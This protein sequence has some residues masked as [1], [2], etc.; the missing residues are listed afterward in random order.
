MNKKVLVGIVAGLCL[1]AAILVLIF[2]SL[3][4]PKVVGEGAKKWLA[5]Y[6]IYVDGKQYKA[7]NVSF[8]Q[9]SLYKQLGFVSNKIDL[10][11]NVTEAKEAN[12]SLNASDAYGEYKPEL[13]RAIE[14]VVKQPRVEEIRLV[15]SLPKENFVNVFGEPVPNK[16]YS[17]AALMFNIKVVNV[18]NV[19]EEVFVRWDVKKGDKS[20]KDQLGFWREVID[21]DES[22]NLLRTKIYGNATSIPVDFGRI[23]IYFDEDYIYGKL[24][25]EIGKV[26]QWN[27]DEGKA[28]SFN[29]THI[30]LDDNNEAAGKDVVVSIKILG[31]EEGKIGGS[32]SKNANVDFDVFIMSYC[33]Y[34]LQFVKGLL[35]VWEEFDDKANIN[36][37]FVSYTM[38]GQ[39]EADENARMVC[40]R[41]E[42]CEKYRDYLKCFVESGNAQACIEKV[43]IDKEKLSDCVANR[44]KRYLEE[45]AKLN[46]QYGVRGSPTAVING[47]QVEIWP[48]S[49][50]NIAKVLCDYLQPKPEECSLSFSQE[51]PSP[52]FGLSTSSSGQQASCGA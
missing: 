25:P 44:A 29:E 13:R 50:A 15:F 17:H 8:Y 5:S 12:I 39:K 19:S 9:G 23:D 28:V 45:D 3:P 51:N 42:Q 10:L 20:E 40:I 11:L 14:R 32:C 30:I 1:L 46:E 36:V 41:E 16:T 33:P 48:R 4:H 38:H 6:V 31:V 35:P 27:G 43:G 47:K 52:G 24:T 7:G 34:G 2:T 22:N 37:R 49:P 21:V 26:V 18:S